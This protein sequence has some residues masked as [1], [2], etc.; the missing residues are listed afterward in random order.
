MTDNIIKMVLDEMP[1]VVNSDNVPTKIKPPS[2][3]DSIED[4]EKQILS[5]TPDYWEI[6]KLRQRGKSLRQIQQHFVGKYT[7]TEISYIIEKVIAVNARLASK[8]VEILRQGVL[9]EINTLKQAIW[10]G[11]EIDPNTHE[12]ILSPTQV[13]TLASLIDREILL[14]GLNK[15]EKVEVD[16]THKVD[17]SVEELNQ[18]LE[19]FREAAQRK[20]IDVTPSEDK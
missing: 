11:A 13:K 15:P 12:T 19:R 20:V 3:L 10:S 16:I 14:Q 17:R 5:F 6:I 1:K 9:D 2:K 8:D 7:L 4:V 18:R